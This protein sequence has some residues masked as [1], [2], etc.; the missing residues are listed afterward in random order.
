MIDIFLE[1]GHNTNT[2]FDMQYDDFYDRRLNGVLYT[3]FERFVRCNPVLLWVPQK[4]QEA[5]RKHNLGRE[6]WDR[7][8]EQ[9]RL[10]RKELGVELL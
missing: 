1:G 6:F 10:V 9:F 7:K 8:M 3:S 4:M 2:L 5:F